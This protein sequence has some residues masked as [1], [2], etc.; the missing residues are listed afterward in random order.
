MLG[1]ASPA[2]SEWLHCSVPVFILTVLI[3][4]AV[5]GNRL[6]F[7]SPRFSVETKGVV[8]LRWNFVS[9]LMTWLFVPASAPCQKHK[10]QFLLKPNV[11]LPHL[12]L[13]FLL[14]RDRKLS[15][16][17][18]D[19]L[20]NVIQTESRWYCDDEDKFIQVYPVL[21]LA[22]YGIHFNDSDS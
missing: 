16:G 2:V 12:A 18:Y 4:L 6:V 11:P 10:G 8:L 22:Q 15:S 20:L 13:S 9:L 5:P 3:F 21:C 14:W 7:P 19:V 17:P 1:A